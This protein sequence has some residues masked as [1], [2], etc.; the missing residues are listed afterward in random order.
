MMNNTQTSPVF[1]LS[2]GRSGTKMMEKLLAKCS[3]IEIHHEYLCNIIQPLGTKYYM[4]LISHEEAVAVVKETFLSSI[5]LCEKKIWMDSSNKLCWILPVLLDVFP[6]AKFVHL[7]R[8]GRRV[9][10]SYFNKLHGEIYDDSSVNKLR[11]YLSGLSEVKPP[12]EKKYWWPLLTD[13]K[14]TLEHFCEKSQF[15]KI[16]LHWHY[17]NEEVRRRLVKVSDGNKLTVKLEGLTSDKK[18]FDRFLAF[19]DVESGQI[20]FEDLGRPHNVHTPVS[21]ELTHDQQQIFWQCARE[22]MVRYGYDQTE[23][24]MVNY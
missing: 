6:D 19:L 13:E 11:M 21:F 7:I 18:E 15:E 2:S 1:L 12:A 8:D 16:C 23:D 20:K 4:G 3:D 24:Y 14:L 10:S 5:L 17:I 22:S 9:V